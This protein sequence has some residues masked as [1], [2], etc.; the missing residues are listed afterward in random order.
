V[1]VARSLTVGTIATG[2][3]TGIGTGIG[4]GTGRL[5]KGTATGTTTD[6]VMHVA[7]LA[8]TGNGMISAP[9]GGRRGVFLV[10]FCHKRKGIL[11]QHFLPLPLTKSGTI[12]N[13]QSPYC[14]AHEMTSMHGRDKKKAALALPAHTVVR[15]RDVEVLC[16]PGAVEAFR[17]GAI[18]AA[19]AVIT[20]EYRSAPT[21]PPPPLG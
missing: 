20:G 14:T 6:G 12:H 3:A 8:E 10:R 19:A 11:P 18:S 2:I 7:A 13:H 21:P 15:L 16:A 4:I 9:I 17:K 5:D 1:V